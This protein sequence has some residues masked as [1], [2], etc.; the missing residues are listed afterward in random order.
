VGLEIRR[1]SGEELK[2]IERQSREEDKREQMTT[3]KE[4]LSWLVG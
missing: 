1:V 3:E 2:V 4:L